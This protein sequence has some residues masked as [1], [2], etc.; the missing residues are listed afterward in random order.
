MS[1]DAG[2]LGASGG[3]ANDIYLVLD[4][5]LR[6]SLEGS[7]DE[8]QLGLLEEAWRTLSFCIA[9]GVIQHLNPTPSTDP[10][11]D[12]AFAEVFSSSAQDAAYWDWLSDFGAVFRDWA[13]AAGTLPQLHSALDGFFA[14]NPTP[15]ELRG[16]LR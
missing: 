8:Q 15:T 2:D 14:S 3:L 13:S 7:L 10:P 11:T 6:P 12:P 16:V 4:E 5:H 9:S 1:L